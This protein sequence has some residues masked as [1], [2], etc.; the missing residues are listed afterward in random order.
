MRYANFMPLLTPLERLL[1]RKS[2]RLGQWLE[3]RAPAIRKLLATQ[4][5]YAATRSTN[6]SEAA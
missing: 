2:V 6:S 4:I 3:C 1:P 5:A